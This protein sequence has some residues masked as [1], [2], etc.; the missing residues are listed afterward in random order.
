MERSHWLLGYDRRK[1][2][3]LSN[4]RAKPNI[5]GSAK[6]VFL[7]WKL[8][9]DVVFS[10]NNIESSNKIERE[11]YSSW[12]QFVFNVRDNNEEISNFIAKQTSENRLFYV[13]QP[14][15]LLRAIVWLENGLIHNLVHWKSVQVENIVK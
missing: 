6:R 3:D 1:S 9:V 13:F 11:R 15:Q 8:F 14:L 10:T 4:L 5:I 7:K 12:I 2:I